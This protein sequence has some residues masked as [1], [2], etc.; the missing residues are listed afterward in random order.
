MPLLARQKLM[1]HFNSSIKSLAALV[2]FSVLGASSAHGRT[3]HDCPYPPDMAWPA[4]IRFLRVDLRLPILE[5]DREAGYILFDYQQDKKVYRAALELLAFE[6]SSGRPGTRLSVSV[7]D[8]PQRVEAVLLEKLSRKLKDDL[9]PP[10]PLR[11]KPTGGGDGTGSKGNGDN[12]KPK[13]SREDRSR[14]D[15]EDPNQPVRGE[16]G[17]PRLP[18]RDLPRPQE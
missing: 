14:N 9:G 18:T 4:A 2:V 12:Q 6:D 13:V 15:T 11:P 7:P 8:L 17:L 3:L 16:D 1:P 10:P 5:K